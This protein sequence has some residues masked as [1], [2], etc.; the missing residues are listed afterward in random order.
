M[1]TA[2]R[3]QDRLYWAAPGRLLGHGC[4]RFRVRVWKPRLL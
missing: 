1:L 3:D 2:R 4:V